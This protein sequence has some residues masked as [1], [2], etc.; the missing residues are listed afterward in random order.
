MFF[1]Y[2]HIFCLHEYC[3]LYSS[4]CSVIFWKCFIFELLSLIVVE[5]LDTGQ[6]Q[7][8][9]VL[10]VNGSADGSPV[11][12]NSHGVLPYCDQASPVCTLRCTVTFETIHSPCYY[13]NG[14][15]F[16]AGGSTSVKELEKIGVNATHAHPNYSV[17]F[18][19]R[20]ISEYTCYMNEMVYTQVEVHPG[21]S[22]STRWQTCMVRYIQ[23][24]LSLGKHKWLLQLYH[25]K[26]VHKNEFYCC[27]CNMLF[28]NT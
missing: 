7:N 13:I 4:T 25:S 12:L 26:N 22:F 16:S 3:T 8:G 23:G 17:K 14:S 21:K 10:S 28:Y 19:C 15:C 6:A 27:I 5:F 18:P 1:T 24:V 11:D 2:F 9:A 20:A